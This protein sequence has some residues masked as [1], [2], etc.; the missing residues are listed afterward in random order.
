MI[1]GEFQE[2][3]EA[4]D[5]DWQQQH[6]TIPETVVS[7]YESNSR[8]KTPIADLFSGLVAVDHSNLLE[9][10]VSSVIFGSGFTGSPMPPPIFGPL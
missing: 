5:V 9:R 10:T 7:D 1:I 4:E 6:P 3:E 8:A 2:Y